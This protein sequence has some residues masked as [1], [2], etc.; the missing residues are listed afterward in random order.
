MYIPYVNSPILC[1]LVITKLPGVVSFVKIV[2]FTLV[3]T[4]IGTIMI[5]AIIISRER[6][7]QKTHIVAGAVASRVR[8]RRRSVTEVLS[9]QR[10]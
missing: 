9:I 8:R 3:A 2:H 4:K 7:L 10:H 1:L 6:I 5:V